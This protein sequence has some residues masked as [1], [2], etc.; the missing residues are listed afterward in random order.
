VAHFR[1]WLPPAVQ[2]QIID[3]L[4]LDRHDDRA[5]ILAVAQEAIQRHEREE[6]Q[7]TVQVLLD[8]VG[9]GGLAVLGQQDTLT[10]VNTARVQKLVLQE[11]FRSDGWCCTHCHYIGDGPTPSQCPVC[12]G[13][14]TA[15]ELGEGM[16]QAV[17]QTD[18]VVQV[19]VPDER[20]AA[21]DGVGA[22]LRYRIS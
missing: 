11:D 15:T 17:L 19:I 3:T 4:S 6:E 10:A 1:G 16:V 5:R 13:Q 22:L 14:T 2:Q 18:G 7:A 8:R 12:G 21:Y 9:H 20:L